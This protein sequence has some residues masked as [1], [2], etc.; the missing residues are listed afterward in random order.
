MEPTSP[1][2]IHLSRDGRRRLKP[3][4]EDALLD[5]T[6]YSVPTFIARIRKPSFLDGPLNSESGRSIRIAIFLLLV[7]SVLLTGGL[8]LFWAF[9]W[10][11]K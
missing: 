5:T 4:E 8:L 9:R 7:I 11:L 2:D 1:Q 3:E 6:V 10:M